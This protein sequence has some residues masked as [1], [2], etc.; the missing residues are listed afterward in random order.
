[1]ESL[2]LENA[3]IRFISALSFRQT[4]R[5]LTF[6]IARRFNQLQVC[7]YVNIILSVGNNLRFEK[8]NK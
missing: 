6:Q 7:L 1:M 3:G 4:R 5:I 2:A 8:G